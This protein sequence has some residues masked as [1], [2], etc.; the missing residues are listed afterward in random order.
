[1]NSNFLERIAVPVRLSF[2][3]IAVTT[4]EF[5]R[6]NKLMHE[7]ANLAGK[8]FIEMKYKDSISPNFFSKLVNEVKS[9]AQNMASQKEYSHM[10]EEI[11]SRDGIVVY[12]QFYHERL[13]TQP[14]SAASLRASLTRLEELG[15]NYV[16]ATKESMND[17]FAYNV[18][19]PAME[20][21][22]I[23][24]ILDSALIPFK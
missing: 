7:A 17:E 14:D 6:A 22:E 1:M 18:A 16:I 4:F 3:V 10:K 11:L 15:I 2:P 12:D 21:S 23:A 24:E 13:R 9:E 20:D 8:H 19:L 5:A